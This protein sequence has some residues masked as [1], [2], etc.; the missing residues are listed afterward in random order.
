M[1]ILIFLLVFLAS[2]DGNKK[3]KL[4]D[5]SPYDQQTIFAGQPISFNE[6]DY[7]LIEPDSD[8]R[9]RNALFEGIRKGDF[10]NQFGQVTPNSQTIADCTIIDG[11]K[12]ECSLAKLDFLHQLSAPPSYDDIF[13]RLIVTE[14]WMAENFKTLLKLL[15]KDIR[16]LFASVT[17]VII[18]PKVPMGFFFPATGAM[19]LSPEYLWLTTEQKEKIDA[20]KKADN[21]CHH[22]SLFNFNFLT[23]YVNNGT[24]IFYDMND[25]MQQAWQAPDSNDT[26]PRGPENAKLS[27]ASLLYHELAH[28]RDYFPEDV[29]ISRGHFALP[30][31]LRDANG[32]AVTSALYTAY[33]LL[34][35]TGILSKLSETL[36]KRQPIDSQLIN[37][38]LSYITTAFEQDFS[39]DVYSFS[40]KTEDMALLFE[41][42]MMKYHFNLDREI[43]FV[44]QLQPESTTCSNLFF[45]F[46]AVNRHLDDA[47][48]ER[49]SLVSRLM[50]PEYDFRDY[51]QNPPEKASSS[52]CR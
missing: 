26:N 37:L 32:G 43:A 8:C 28:A 47:I 51:F 52:W 1:K 17:A 30:D 23:R 14:F 6:L 20:W 44:Q 10:V 9:Q 33:P 42:F 5:D 19:Y 12:S 29:L 2:C 21:Y 40:N 36:Y 16:Q 24:V 27:V 22:A 45:Q 38:P 34:D 50:L 39:T 48:L 15:P 25:I 49:V 7:S 41:E 31:Y 46:K 4:P 13:D 35:Y 3:K 18:H 11:L